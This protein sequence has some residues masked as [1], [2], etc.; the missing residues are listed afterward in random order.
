M[1]FSFQ[2]VPELR[3]GDPKVVTSHRPAV[4]SL[5]QPPQITSFLGGSSESKRKLTFMEHLLGARRDHIQSP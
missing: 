4:T 1:S 5:P 3:E 2:G